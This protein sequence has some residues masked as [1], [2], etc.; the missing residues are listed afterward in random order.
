VVNKKV[1]GG[2]KPNNELKTKA[3]RKSENI[4]SSAGFF[5]C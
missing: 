1:S 5:V 2:K 3:C 4:P